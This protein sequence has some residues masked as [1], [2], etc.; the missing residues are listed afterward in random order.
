MMYYILCHTLPMILHPIYLNINCTNL[1]ITIHL[2]K[3][4]CVIK[5][6]VL[7][8]NIVTD[9][10]N[11]NLN[12]DLT[13]LK[14]RLIVFFRDFENFPDYP[15]VFIFI[16]HSVALFDPWNIVRIVHNALST[17]FNKVFIFS[18]SEKKCNCLKFKVFLNLRS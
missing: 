2:K 14:L 7:M 13:I 8:T 15:S 18:F 12:A 5:C 9:L 11:F 16:K 6:I 4:T 1:H 17:G 3:S 10:Q